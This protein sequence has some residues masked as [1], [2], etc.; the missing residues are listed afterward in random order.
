MQGSKIHLVNICPN[1]GAAE[2]LDSQ[3]LGE[4]PFGENYQEDTEF[5]E[6]V[7]T[8]FKIFEVVLNLILLIIFLNFVKKCLWQAGQCSLTSS[9]SIVL[10]SEC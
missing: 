9:K 7:S 6:K 4:D 8:Y 10:S 3:Q 1:Y 2:Q 5:W